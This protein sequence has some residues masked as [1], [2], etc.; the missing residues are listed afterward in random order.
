MQHLEKA[1]EQVKSVELGEGKTVGDFVVLDSNEHSVKFVIQNGPVKENG[2]SGCQVTNMLQFVKEVYKSLQ[3]AFPCKENASTIQY[4]E[5]ALEYQ[6]KRNRDRAERKVEGF[7][8][9]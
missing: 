1:F 2:L 6:A 4:I 7:D 9:V 5:L 3:S 8:I